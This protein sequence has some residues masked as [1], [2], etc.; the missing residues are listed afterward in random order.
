MLTRTTAAI[1]W[2]PRRCWTRRSRTRGCRTSCSAASSPPSAASWISGA[3]WTSHAH[4]LSSIPCCS[5]RSWD[6]HQWTTQTKAAW[7]K[8]WVQI[9]RP[10]NVCISICSQVLNRPFM[11]LDHHHPWCSVWHQCEERRVWVPVLHREA[12]VPGREAEGPAHG[13]VQEPAVPRGAAK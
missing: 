10:E 5:R 7:R 4:G 1:S 8:R 3:S 12:G 6:T 11:H 2:Q 13:A 9:Q